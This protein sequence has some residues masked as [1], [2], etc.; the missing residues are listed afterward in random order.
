M[1]VTKTASES[2]LTIEVQKGLDRAGDPVF[3]KKT[4]SGVKNDADAQNVYDVAE[5]IKGVM[6]AATKDTYINVSSQLT[7]A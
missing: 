1:A 7:N 6:E 3:V 2:S 5:A 4:F